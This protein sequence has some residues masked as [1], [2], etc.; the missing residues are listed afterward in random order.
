MPVHNGAKTIKETIDSVINQTYRNFEFIIINDGSDDETEKIINSYDDE[1]IVYSNLS[2][3]LGI[4]PALNIGISLCEGKFIARIDADDTMVPTRLEKQVEFMESHPEYDIVGS[5]FKVI[6]RKSVVF[7]DNYEVTMQDLLG[8]NRLCHSSVMMRKSSLEKLPYYYQNYFQA[9]EDYKL[10]FTCLAYGLRLY[11]MPEVLTNYRINPNGECVK[12][13]NIQEVS[14]LRIKNCYSQL[15]KDHSSAPLT[16]IIGFYNENE[17]I[18]KTVESIRS[19]AKNTQILLVDDCS[20]DGYDY[21]NIAK[22]YDCIYLKTPKRLGVAQARDFGIDHCPTEHFIILDGHM[23]FYHF[24][25]D[26]LMLNV[27][28]DHPNAIVCMNTVVIHKDRKINGVSVYENENMEVRGM[29]GAFGAY[30]NLGNNKDDFTAKWTYTPIKEEYRNQKIIPIPCVFGAT[31]G[32]SKTWWKHIDGLRGLICW[33]YDEPLMSL[34][35]WLSGGECLLIKDIGVGHIYRKVF[36]YEVQGKDVKANNYFMACLFS[37]N[38][39]QKQYFL[40]QLK[41]EYG[42]EF[43]DKVQKIAEENKDVYEEAIKNFRKIQKYDLKWF[44][45]NLNK[46]LI[47]YDSSFASLRGF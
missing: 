47:K 45:E 4:V 25:W 18:E 3:N 44:F 43:F 30:I 16:C 10:W 17:E 34:K 27:L 12:K 9:A 22:I 1:K 23:R 11:V 33:G 32:C 39:I 14:T 46:P 38:E 40:N 28:K 15:G 6:G 26:I 37:S 2:S 19:T 36:P 42:K 24:N 21:Q 29:D 35:T 31:Y 13:K 7:P 41:G 5:S 20:D 8:K